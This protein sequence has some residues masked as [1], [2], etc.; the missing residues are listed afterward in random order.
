[1]TTHNTHKRQTYTPTVEFESAIPTSERS[2]THA[3]D[4]V[5][6]GIGQHPDYIRP[7]LSGGE[8]LHYLQ[9]YVIHFIIFYI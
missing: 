4:R 8:I 5:A 7:E 3:L 6:T 1:M 2:Q 9:S